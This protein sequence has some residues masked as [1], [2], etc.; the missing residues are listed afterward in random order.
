MVR[1]DHDISEEIYKISVPKML[2]LTQGDSGLIP[3]ICEGLFSRI[4]DVTR[5]GD[6]SFRTEVSYLEIY[7][8]R[9]RDL[10]RRKS[11]KTFNLRVREHP[12]EGPYVEDLS[13][14]L[15]QNY[16]DVEE[17]MD[18]GN[19]NRTTAATGMNDVSSRSHA[20]FTINF[21]QAKFDA[22]MPC[23]T[24]SKIHLV[25]LAGS[26]RADA[27]G[28]TGVRLK[29]GGN[30]NKSLVTLGN[31]I[32]ALADLSQDAANHLAKKKQ[33]FV[34]YRDSVLT[35]LLKDSLGGNAKTIMIA[36]P[37]THYTGSLVAP[38]LFDGS[39]NV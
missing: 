6:A 18:A 22:E 21:T 34:P 33:V 10:L 8:E 31:V 39:N 16:S 20:I 36:I 9:V 4:A 27:T 25:D 19:I 1:L 2:F 23:E 29:E 38:K 15:V 35:W 5:K 37:P 30:I 3:R 32:S 12:K 28:A 14:H 13:K 7:N 26:E 17:L 11:S 24:V